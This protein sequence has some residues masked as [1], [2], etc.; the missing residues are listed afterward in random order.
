MNHLPFLLFLFVFGNAS[1]ETGNKNHA[2]DKTTR[3]TKIQGQEISDKS[4]TDKRTKNSL[5]ENKNY[6]RFISFMA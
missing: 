4:Y 3:S 5:P 1:N 6:V 2:Y